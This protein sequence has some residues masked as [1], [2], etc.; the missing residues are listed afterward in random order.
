MGTSTSQ[1]TEPISAPE[2]EKRGLER[3]SALLK[4]RRS[5]RARVLLPDG[6]EM[7][8]PDSVLTILR[9]AADALASG[10]AMELVRI[11]QELT[12]QQAADMLNVSR[13]YVTRLADAGD[14]PAATTRGGHRRFRLA[15]VLTYKRRRDAQRRRALDEMMDLTE[16]Y[17][18]Y[19]GSK[20]R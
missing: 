13:Q 9:T 7:E 4:D 19:D 10:D 1:D 18:G 2:S 6:E 17:G 20:G 14:L 12:S 5:S 16:E 8:L 3:L 15:D 11:D